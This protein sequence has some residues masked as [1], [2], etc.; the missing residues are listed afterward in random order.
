M[1]PSHAR[2]YMGLMRSNHTHQR[3]AEFQARIMHAPGS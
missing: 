1:Y 2:L 3:V